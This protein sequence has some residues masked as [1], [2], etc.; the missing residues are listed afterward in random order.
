MK[1][2][3]GSS[4][5]EPVP[6]PPPKFPGRCHLHCVSMLLL[7]KNSK[8]FSAFVNRLSLASGGR[9]APFILKFILQRVSN[10]C[11]ELSAGLKN[12]W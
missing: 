8:R 3:I 9:Y 11:Q 10:S 6:R 1:E 2:T 7:P 12:P 4:N 5:I